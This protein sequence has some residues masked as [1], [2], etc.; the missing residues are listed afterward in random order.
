MRERE[1]ES[2]RDRKQTKHVQ[3]MN[4]LGHRYVLYV[5]A[6]THQVYKGATLGSVTAQRLAFRGRRCCLL[7]LYALVSEPTL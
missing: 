1:R 2:A 6:V 7:S 3:M 5:V 4:M